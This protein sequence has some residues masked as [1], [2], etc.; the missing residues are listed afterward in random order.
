VYILPLLRRLRRFQIAPQTPSA[1]AA[2]LTSNPSAKP[3]SSSRNVAKK[4]K[5]WSSIDQHARRA[6]P[7]LTG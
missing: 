2:T 1:D 7:R 3:F 5:A 6:G 4:E